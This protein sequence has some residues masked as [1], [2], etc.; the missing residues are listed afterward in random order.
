MKFSCAAPLAAAALIFLFPL[1]T[2]SA[3]S[4]AASL[5]A[6][7][8]SNISKRIRETGVQMKEDMKQARARLDARKAQEEVDRKHEAERAR[9]QAIQEE[10]QR[11]AQ[12]AAQARAR[13]E[14]AA[15]AA[16]VE[17]DRVEAERVKQKLAAEKAERE[18]QHAL[19]APAA[20]EEKAAA[21]AAARARAMAALRQARESPGVKAF[22][23]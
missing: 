3:E 18:T 2:Y 21:T 5:S 1:N 9:Q 12:E 7:E 20:K 19:A 14:A 4:D 8:L 16:Q 15:R 11:Q 10:K 17:R 22:A 13:Q 23:E 6:E